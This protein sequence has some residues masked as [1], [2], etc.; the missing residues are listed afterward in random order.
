MAQSFIDK[1]VF[2]LM[3]DS[4][5][6][7]KG[8]NMATKAANGIKTTLLKTYTALGGIDLFKGMLTSYTDAAHNIDMLNILTGEN[9]VQLQAW[10]KTIQDT[11]GNIN[12]FRGSLRGLNESF[13]QFRNFGQADNKILALFRQGIS[14]TDAQGNWKKGT[15]VLKEIARVIRTIKSESSAWTWASAMGIDEGTFRMMRIYGEN[16]DDI[17]KKNEQWAII[18]KRDIE[19]TR[20]YDLMVSAFKTSWLDLSKTIMSELL[21]V[22]QEQLFPAIRN[23]IEYFR[24]N[25]DGIIG[26]IKT[27][28]DLMLQT[29]GAAKDF[30]EYL[31]AKAAN[32]TITQE[33]N[34]SK[35]GKGVGTALT[36]GKYLTMAN[37]PMLAANYAA[38]KA[39]QY[40]INISKVDVSTDNIEGLTNEIK[41]V[42]QQSSGMQTQ[43]GG[44]QEL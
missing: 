10:E 26:T 7:E 42:A 21:P 44:Q 23:G 12:A 3:L 43:V 37:L 6:F 25:K 18:N 13:A 32:V 19:N 14:P 2:A 35:Y 4:S 17:I 29:A 27:I 33:Q 38:D 31:G 39:Q 5:N 22:I 40:I 36:A 30:A 34:V 11:G 8:A 41:Q 24:E 15:E 16:I 20:K 28:C 1:Y 9:T